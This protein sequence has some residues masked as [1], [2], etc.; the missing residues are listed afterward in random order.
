MTA[1]EVHNVSPETV[2]TPCVTANKDEEGRTG[3]KYVQKYRR[4]QDETEYENVDLLIGNHQHALNEKYIADRVVIL[5][6]FNSGPFLNR[7]PSDNNIRDDPADLV[8]HFLTSHDSLPLNDITDIIEARIEQSDR[9]L[10]A[11]DWLKD[12]GVDRESAREL[13]EI[14]P[15]PFETTHVLTPLLTL[16]LLL[17]EKKSLGMEHVH[18]PDHWEAA[19]VSRGVQ[20]ARDR[21]SGEMVI[22]DPPRLT[23]AKQVVGLDALP[24]EK[25]WE[26]VYDCSFTTKQILPRDRLDTYLRDAFDMQLVQLADGSNLYSGGN[27]SSRDDKRFKAVRIIE[28]STYPVIAPKKALEEYRSR[29]NSS[30]FEQCIKSDPDCTTSEYSTGDLCALN[31]ASITSSNKFAEESLGFVSGC[32]YPGDDIV[33][34]WSVLCGEATEP[35]R[36]PDGGLTGFTGFGDDIYRH[37]TSNKVFQAILRFGRSDEIEDT[38]TVYVNTQALPEFLS[39]S[40]EYTIKDER[41]AL[42]EVLGI[43]ALINAAWDEDQFSKQT[44]STLNTKITEQLYEQ[45]RGDTG[46]VSNDHIRSI[47][48]SLDEDLIIR[49]EDAATGGA[50]QYRWDGDEALHRCRIDDRSNYLLRSGATLYFLRLEED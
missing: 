37:F 44:A 10:T 4:L 22:L 1:V 21:N 40:I 43:E 7:F 16:S 35:N 15:S 38:T 46:D 49:Y 24:T 23:S 26:A 9:L 25:M 3:C 45:N 14:T 12:T 42:K 32:P 29:S 30:W 31:Y 34:Q 17:M 5:D 39:A 19:G 48:R 6:E 18:A 41:N 13:L 8:S 20:C 50:D 33:T 28:D 47:L 27:V 11:V 2:Y 36:S